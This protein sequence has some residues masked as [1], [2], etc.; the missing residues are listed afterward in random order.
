MTKITSTPAPSTGKQYIAL[1]S[2]GLDS[3]A[4]IYRYLRAGHSVHAI[5]C[6]LINN[7]GQARKEIQARKQLAQLFRR[8]FPTTFSC[9][10]DRLTTLQH[11][12]ESFIS[13]R[14]SARLVLP[15]APLWIMTAL[16]ADAPSGEEIQAVLIGYV[17]GDDALEY[18]AELRA[19]WQGFDGLVHHLPPLEFPLATVRKSELVE[20]LPPDYL[21]HVWVC[22]EP[23]KGRA[24]DQCCDC[25]RHAIA[26]A[27]ARLSN[28]E[29]IKRL[30]QPVAPR[31]DAEWVRQQYPSFFT[32]KSLRGGNRRSAGREQVTAA[33]IA[34]EVGVSE[35]TIKRMRSA[36][37]RELKP[38]IKKTKGRA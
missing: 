36:Y 8:D 31:R 15:Q 23:Q 18:E 33:K 38:G 29:L 13:V 6:Q 37:L 7:E 20:G 9:W 16:Y 24:C 5:S 32:P 12:G 19:A 22:G 1:W 35:K 3:T 14:G 2:G 17:S 28:E 34:T 30:R 27:E 4:M 21:R 26:I 11:T 10:V 25:R